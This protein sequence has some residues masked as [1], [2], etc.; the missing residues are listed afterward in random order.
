MTALLD[1]EDLRVTFGGTAAV[2]GASLKVEKGETHCLVVKAWP[3]SA[4]II[5]RAAPAR[6][7]RHG[8]DV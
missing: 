2:R 4:S 6:H 3:I 5:G 7:D 8:A 1:V